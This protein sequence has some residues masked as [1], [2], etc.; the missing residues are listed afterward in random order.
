MGLDHEGS[1]AIHAAPRRE[2]DW[3]AVNR[4][5][6]QGALTRREVEVAWYVSL[7]WRNRQIADEMGL[8]VRT[9]KSHIYNIGKKL[10]GCGAPRGRIMRWVW[11]Q[12]KRGQ[13]EPEPEPGVQV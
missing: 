13:E 11:E 5:R 9:V 1:P 12:E 7:N 3:R 2:R 10:G 4:T 6:Y 8:A